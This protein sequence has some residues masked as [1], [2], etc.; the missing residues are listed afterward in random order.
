MLKR[1]GKLA[2]VV[3]AWIVA[4]APA[5]GVAQ[6]A[7]P[8]APA[9][10]SAGS[11]LAERFAD[12]AQRTLRV[13]K[14]ITPGQ[15]DQAVVLLRAAGRLAPNELRFQRL[16]VEAARSSGDESAELEALRNWRR[17]D[18][19]D[20]IPQVRTVEISASKMQT[21]DARLSYFA[22]LSG[23]AGVSEEVRAQAAFRAAQLSVERGQG[24]RAKQFLDLALR[25][26]PNH[27]EALRLSARQFENG[28]PVERAAAL[29]AILRANPAQPD[30]VLS[31]ADLYAD[32]GMFPE[33]VEWY[34]L[35]FQ[36]L[37]RVGRTPEPE[38]VVSLASV[39][40]QSDQ[41][42]AADNLLNQ[43]LTLPAG[44]RNPEVWFMRL[45]VDKAGGDKVKYDNSRR[46]AMNVL[47][48]RFQ[49]A[50]TQAGAPG[51]T[52]RPVDAPGS[53]TV[54]DLSDEARK[55]AG[56][57][58]ADAKSAYLE[59]ATDLAMFQIYFDRDP[60]SAGPL[61][62]AIKL[63]ASEGDTTATRLEGWSYFVDGK[64][65]EARVKFSA[66]AGQNPLAA[67]GL[68][69]LDDKDPAAPLT[70]E[71]ETRA[72]TLLVSHPSGLVGTTL[73]EALRGRKVRLTEST[74]ATVLRQNLTRFPKDLLR[75]PLQPEQFYVIRADPLKTSHAFGEPMLANVTITN[76]SAYP[77][78][79][80]PDGL[81][82]PNVWFDAQWR[83]L[84]KQVFPGVAVDRWSGASVLQPRQ[85]TG[86]VV[87]L[88]QGVLAEALRANPQ[89]AL[90]LSGSVTT[91][92]TGL[93]DG[94]VGPGPGGYR[95]QFN[96]LIER[97]AYPA[98]SDEQRKKLT[99]AVNTGSAAHRLGA[100]ELLR[101]YTNLLGS[102]NTDAKSAEVYE[103]FANAIRAVATDPTPAVRAWAQFVGFDLN[104]APAARVSAVD[105]MAVDPAWEV[106]LLSV[107][108][109]GTLDGTA[110]DARLAKLAADAE[111]DAM[112]RAYAQ[113]SIQTTLEQPATQ[114]TTSAISQP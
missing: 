38:T 74:D 37:V 18:A 14:T 65:D 88:D 60:A 50:R 9:D 111:P 76:T 44:A 29:W 72:R 107:T 102:A 6:V 25:L 101:V 2:V 61:V 85:S 56:G 21:A 49:T 40:L 90:Q 82:K 106:R 36:Q 66:L 19:N 83:G 5:L 79:V 48:N 81:I 17:I 20:R 112:V 80:G 69:L 104:P 89:V 51:A 99:D 12:L 68:F 108:A 22:D 13:G 39:L 71:L 77:L 100:L 15:W 32:A 53:V 24:G 10:E 58:D 95:V 110:R 1:T 87:R 41:A 33:A 84:A 52:T 62:E 98:A 94:S 86:F 73:W 7:P 63:L 46:S 11:A 109:A 43:M 16:L 57:D 96:R 23:R 92:P 3:S 28:T 45:L 103:I 91:N 26:N 70:P 97:V 34:G 78:T 55:L 47:Y 114:P 35:G 67:L 54:P 8:R 42:P 4:F 75:A 113:A 27:A 30:T 64:R 31:V 93:G 59:A 105:A